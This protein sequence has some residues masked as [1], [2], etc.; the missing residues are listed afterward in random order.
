MG[1]G[2]LLVLLGGQARYGVGLLGELIA[3]TSH[4]HER[5]V[6]RRLL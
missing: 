1:G 2:G 5:I 6:S 4:T 3:A